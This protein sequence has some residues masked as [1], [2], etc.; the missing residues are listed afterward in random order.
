MQ[1]ASNYLMIKDV[2]SMKMGVRELEFIKL[3]LKPYESLKDN[4]N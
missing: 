1:Y 4:L 2:K 3:S